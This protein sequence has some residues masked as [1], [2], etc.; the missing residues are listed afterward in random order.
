MTFLNARTKDEDTN[1]R[2]I[3]EYFRNIMPNLIQKNGGKE[4]FNWK[5]FECT[6]QT[7]THHVNIK[8]QLHLTPNNIDITQFDK[9]F[10]TARSTT[11]FAPIMLIHP[12]H[13][14]MTTVSYD[15]FHRSQEPRGILQ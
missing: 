1:Q 4:H 6:E 12:F 5:M 14:M 15:D 9:T 7:D 11:Q 2:D 8:S 3:Y 13:S 10:I